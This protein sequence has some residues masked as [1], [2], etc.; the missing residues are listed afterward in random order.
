MSSL[1]DEQRKRIEA[2]RARALA[3]LGQKR[4]AAPHSSKNKTGEILQHSTSDRNKT[5]NN[6]Q[7]VQRVATTS[8]DLS[9]FKYHH[10]KNSTTSPHK[11]TNQGLVSTAVKRQSTFNN[12]HGSNKTKSVNDALMKAKVVQGT[13]VLLNK[14]RFKV[15]VGYHGKLVGV[16]KS[17]PSKC[18]DAQTRTWNYLLEDYDKLMSLCKPLANEVTL[19]GLP[20]EVARLFLPQKKESSVDDSK[21]EIAWDRIDPKLVGSLMPFQREGVIFSIK[22]NGRVLLADDMGLGKTVQAIAVAAYYKT[23]WPLLV[24][25]PSS[26]RMTWRRAFLRW[27]PSVRPDLINVVLTGKD[28]PNAGLVNVVS[29]DILVKQIKEI[30]NQRYKVIIADECHSIKNRKAERTKALMPLLK[31]SSHVILLSGTPALSRPSELYTQISAVNPKLFPSYH[32]YGIRYCAA[33]KNKFGWDYSGSSNMEELQLILEECIMIRRLKKVVLDQLPSKTREV[34]YLDPSLIKD[35][36]L[37]GAEKQ[38][39]KAK[40]KERRSALLEYFGETSSAKARAVREYIMDLLEGGHKLIVFA[41]HREMLDA[42]SE[43]LMKAK[44]EYI[45]IDGRTPS[46]RRQQLCDKFQR[47]TATRAA[48]LSVTAA[49]TGLTLTAATCVVFAELFWN[50]GVL[51][52]AEDRAYRIGQKNSVVIHYLIAK[53]TA[54]DYLWPLIQKK[55][56]VL[57]EAGLN[58]ENFADLDTKTFQDPK[59]RDLKDLFETMIDEFEDDESFVKDCLENKDNT[60]IDGETACGSGDNGKNKKEQAKLWSERA[61]CGETSKT[62]SDHI[63][64]SEASMINDVSEDWF[65]NIDKDDWDD[66]DLDALYSSIEEPS[67]KRKRL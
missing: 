52:Q 14:T 1:T 27:L 4:N 35:K 49:N 12:F 62:N 60:E 66:L 16:L 58:K 59:Q 25:V 3:K 42:I 65:D 20:K 15:V 57:S 31:A 41:H 17:L 51:V 43:S 26:L 46:V 6:G 47:H 18:Y 11:A 64:N 19:S 44:T 48:V 61:D 55:L 5:F 24:V 8:L 67:A 23:K 36:M 40:V 56:D 39:A 9:R 7:T 37:T 28:P 45:R 29:Y 34:V 13:C 50:P 22:Q 30:Q 2:N 10:G 21:T 33:I 32:D 54:D 53:K 38:L 63:E